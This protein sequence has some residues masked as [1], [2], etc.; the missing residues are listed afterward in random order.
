[1]ERQL[2]AGA[3]LERG[4]VGVDGRGQARGVALALAQARKCVP[5]VV[6]GRGPLERQLLAGVDLE[7]G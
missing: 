2:L 7:R 5:E 4:A 1:M 6:L 3:D